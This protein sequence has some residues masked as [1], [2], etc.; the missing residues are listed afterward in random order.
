MYIELVSNLKMRGEIID[1]SSL[2]RMIPKHEGELYRSLFSFGEEIKDY[3]RKTGSVSKF[4]GI[5][6][7]DTVVLDVDG[8][9]EERFIK[10][11]KV[12]NILDNMNVSKVNYQVYFSG[13]GFHIHLHPSLFN[14][15]PTTE[16]HKDLKKVIL[17]NFDTLVD[18][19]YD[20][21]RLIRVPNTVNNKTGLYKIPLTLTEIME[22]TPFD[23]VDLAKEPRYD[24][25]VEILKGHHLFKYT[26]ESED[27]PIDKTYNK[28]NKYNC[29]HTILNNPAPKGGRHNH[30]LRLASHFHRQGYSQEVT[31]SICSGWIN[32]RNEEP[33][34]IKTIADVYQ[35]DSFYS[36]KDELLQKYC[37]K[38]CIFNEDTEDMFDIKDMYLDYQAKT[39]STNEVIDIGKVLMSSFKY[40]VHTGELVTLLGATGMGKST[41]I[42]N[43]VAR[44]NLPTL[45]Y[46]L[47]MPPYQMYR[48]FI[49]ILTGKDKKD[50]TKEDM[51]KGN[52]R[53]KHLVL[54]PKA[55]Y[56]NDL[57]KVVEVYKP[58]VLV[59]DHILL[60]KSQHRDEYAR[61][62]ELTAELKQLALKE[63]LIIFGV[64]QV[65]R[66]SAKEGLST[67]SGKGS[68]SIE[69]D[70][71][72]VLGFS[73]PSPLSSEARIQSLKNREGEHLDVIVNINNFKI[74]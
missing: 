12:L 48:R 69:N 67:Y 11:G 66:D 7:I 23:I 33:D 51:M 46:S 8:E 16:S 54:T 14:I 40:E 19:I 28:T 39:S 32:D 50:L 26:E 20:K 71:D 29:I 61:V 4:D 43:I 52:E 24:F 38:H 22:A 30:V 63:N 65:G 74:S 59:I 10:L 13:R 64:S 35:W 9:T 1:L 47:E 3:V 27:T 5:V 70:S 49:Q 60:M 25:E 73:K 45:F 55:V 18:N 42:Q 15:E 31:K 62:S 58:K 21:M 37:D 44:I 2:E 56:P 41:L 68:G 36:C 6:N 72:K 57:S 17:Q 53:L 34:I